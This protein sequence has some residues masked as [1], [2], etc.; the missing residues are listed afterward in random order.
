[1]TRLTPEG[2][3]RL[4][5]IAARHGVSTDAAET[6]LVALV[7]GG[8]TQAQFSHP[9]LGGMG[10]WSRGGMTMVGDMFN[11]G[12]KMTVDA[13][14]TE[15]SPMTSEPGILAPAPRPESFPPGLQSQSQSS[16]G[17]TSFSAVGGFGTSRWPVALGAPSSTGSQNNMHYAIFPETR[18]LAIDL[19]GQV[20]V[21]DTG[22]HAIS[23]M[24]QQQ[25]GDQSL[26]FTSQ[27]GL[28][29]VADLPRVDLSGAEASE[30]PEPS[31]PDAGA[32]TPD[33]P[34]PSPVETPVPDTPAPVAPV[35]TASSDAPAPSPQPAPGGAKGSAGADEIIGLIRKLADLKD[36]GILTETEFE[37]KKAELLARL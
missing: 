29:R 2:T 6:L 20:E 24:S 34:A 16:G 12:L 22:D 14:C 1:M 17:G 28:V 9:D 31:A 35:K 21:Y 8:G 33:S 36:S 27:Y 11:N 10:Q 13:L 25:G 26:T 32:P 30:Q 23:G 3:A 15:L 5:D 18:R 19:G 7:R 37:A 4:S